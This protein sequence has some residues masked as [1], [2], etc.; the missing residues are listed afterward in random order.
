MSGLGRAFDVWPQEPVEASPVA[1]AIELADA[2]RGRWMRRTLVILWAGF[3]AVAGIGVAATWDRLVNGLV[4]APIPEAV[5]AVAPTVGSAEHAVAEARRLL[6]GGRP[7][8]ALAALDGLRPEEPAYP[9]S[10]QLREEAR[11]AL[12]RGGSKAR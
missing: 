6:D 5:A 12:A 9:F 2:S 11:R 1:D 3:F 10:L 8:E 7:A 4:R